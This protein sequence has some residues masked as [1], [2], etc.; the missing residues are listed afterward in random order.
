MGFKQ[1][2]EKCHSTC[3]VVKS[4]VEDKVGNSKY[5]KDMEYLRKIIDFL[6]EKLADSKYE[7]KV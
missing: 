3:E 5:T 2:I 1:K 6:K 4:E 7:E